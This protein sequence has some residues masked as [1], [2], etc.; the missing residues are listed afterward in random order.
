MAKKKEPAKPQETEIDHGV[1]VKWVNEAD[2]GTIDSRANSEKSRDY[3]DSKQWS[4]AEEK[5][6]RKQKQ[7]ATVINRVKPKIDGLMGMERANKTTAMAFPRTPKHEKAATAATEAIRY[8]L[9]D[10]FYDQIRSSAWENLTI[11][12][13][14]AIEIDVKEKKDGF[15]IG[16]N[17]IMWDRLIYDPH[18]RTKSFK[19]PRYLGQHI[20]LDYD[21]A[22]ERF[23]E[24]RARAHTGTSRR[25]SMACVSA[26][27]S[28]SCTT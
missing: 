1:L 10:N 17:H 15:R 7:A 5:K 8:C 6:L 14:G 2:E 24:A 21:I 4:A 12:G 18:D 20:W 3:Y 11:E 13:T 28:W 26:S 22:L 25:G 27:R 9:Q 16:L 23:P 19:N